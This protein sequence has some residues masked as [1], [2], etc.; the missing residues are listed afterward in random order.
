MIGLVAQMLGPEVEVAREAIKAWDGRDRRPVPFMVR[1]LARDDLY[2]D[3]IA[4]LSK[5][6]DRIVGS[7]ADHLA[8]T[9]NSRPHVVANRLA[10]LCRI[11]KWQGRRI[12]IRGC[13]HRNSHHGSNVAHPSPRGVQ[14]LRDQ[15]VP[16]PLRAPENSVPHATRRALI[17]TEGAGMP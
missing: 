17:T 13:G 6:S 4:S 10:F 8:E 15:H 12:P 5:A 1:L 16:A 3:V 11:D 2:K 7:L 9:L 14:E